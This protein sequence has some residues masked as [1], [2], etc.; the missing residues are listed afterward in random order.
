M[1]GL[2]V[3]DRRTYYCVLDLDG[4]WVAE[5]VVPTKE[6]SL[7]VQFEGKARMRVA[8]EA[9]THSA[10]IS[11]LL[12]KLGHEVIVANPRNLRMISESDSKN[13]RRITPL[14]ARGP[15]FRLR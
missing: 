6:G 13:D 3:S 12:A 10:W 2:D 8:L 15:L 11:R 7:R 14:E 9:G 1:V 4:E 5:G